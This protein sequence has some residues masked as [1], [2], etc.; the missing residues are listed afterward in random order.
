MET[1]SD[2]NLK[3]EVSYHIFLF[4]FQWDFK[5]ENMSLENM[6]FLKR[7]SLENVD[8][9]LD[10]SC[11][12]REYFNIDTPL[13]FNEYI[14][15]Y[16][17]IRGA[18]YDSREKPSGILHQYNYL[19][20]EN[21]RYIIHV[22]NN[23]DPY[24]LKIERI[25]LSLYTTGIGII[26]LHL[27]NHSYLQLQQ[28][29][30]INEF[31][32]RIYPQFLVEGVFTKITKE[33]FLAD[34]L[35][36]V[37]DENREFRDDFSYFNN[38]EKVKDNPCRLSA[39]IM[40]LLGDPFITHN[41]GEKKNFVL[42]TPILDDRMFVLCWFADLKL[43]SRLSNYNKEKKTYRYVEDDDWYKLVFI[44]KASP[45]CNSITMKKQLLQEHTYDRWIGKKDS[46]LFGITR[47]SFIMLNDHQT[48]KVKD[49]L[50]TMYFQMVQLALVQRAS[51]LR[52]SKEATRIAAL[53]TPGDTT[54]KVQELHEKY[55][56][57][58]NKIYYREI[59]AQ[60]QGI[61][62]YERIHQVVKLERDVKDLNREIDELHQYASLCE[63]RRKNKQ[64]H[65]LT[66][67]GA[68][69]IIPAFLTGF[70]GLSIFTSG[71]GIINKSL[72]IIITI[73]IILIA[74]LSGF[75][76]KADRKWKIFLSIVILILVGFMLVLPCL[77]I[78]STAPGVVP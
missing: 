58:V 40:N 6:D 26:S 45:S 11:W 9:L 23:K 39:A 8:A 74:V 57:F 17:F 49:H 42:I 5:K 28:I 61:E 30:E 66:V 62:L 48:T 71:L 12:E 29:L 64:L 41:T 65:I 35:E 47:Y 50:K 63:D 18:L 25:Q 44:D 70:F 78:G 21:P 36:I 53:E 56:Q 10:K 20:S 27:S 69:F 43:C 33:K 75:W 14:Y 13:K 68:L 1:T 73:G 32:R 7:T 19:L 72:Y 59:T 54:G 60:E 16:D 31:G 3:P 15:F 38:I 46:S 76:V 77:G 22:K 52:F 34:Q 24:D 67:L 4:P 51:V 55:L 37:I 2:K